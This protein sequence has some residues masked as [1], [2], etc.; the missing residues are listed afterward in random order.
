MNY[1]EESECSPPLRLRIIKLSQRGKI[2]DEG[3]FILE[4]I[5]KGSMDAGQFHDAPRVFLGGWLEVVDLPEFCPDVPVCLLAG[6]FV[7]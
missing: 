2:S 1:S 7:L 5:K 3:R 6:H 4:M